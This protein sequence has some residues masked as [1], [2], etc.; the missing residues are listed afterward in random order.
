MTK[1]YYNTL[2]RRLDSREGV[3]NDNQ[4]KIMKIEKQ[5]LSKML[6]KITNEYEE[7]KKITNEYEEF[8]KI[9]N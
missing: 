1:I 6:E 8:K 5:V 9:T 2:N 7:F 4:I 3:V